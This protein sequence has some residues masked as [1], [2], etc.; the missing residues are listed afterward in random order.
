MVVRRKSVDAN[1]YECVLLPGGL[2]CGQ[3]WTPALG[4]ML[5]VVP[6]LCD[7]CDGCAGSWVRARGCRLVRTAVVYLW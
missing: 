3:Q 1:I 2:A 4:G 5:L 7:G 6:L